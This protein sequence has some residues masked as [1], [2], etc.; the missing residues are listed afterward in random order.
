[1]LDLVL[2]NATI[3]TMDDNRRVLDNSSIGIENGR[4]LAIGPVKQLREIGAKNVLDCSGKIVIPGMVNTHTHLFQTLSKGLGSD[5]PLFDWFRKAVLPFAQILTE[6]DCRV[7]AL[8]GCVEAIKSG[9]TCLND[10]MYVHPKPKLS[11]AVIGAMRQV[12]VRGILSRGIVDSGRD[13]GMPDVLIQDASEYVEDCERLI[14]SYQGAYNGTIQ[15]W[16][17]PASLWMSSLD[18]FRKSK[19]VSK[20]HDIW[21]TW[22]C[23]ETRGVVD[24]S[25][26][27]FGKTDLRALHEIGFLGPNTLAA[28][29]IWLDEDEISI[30]K[31]QGVKVAHCP[32]ANMYLSDGVARIPYMLSKGITVGLGTDGAA[33]NDNQDM[34]F[35]LKTTPLL[36][37]VSSLDPLAMT[38]EKAFELATTGGANCLGLGRDIGSLEN[39][40]KADLVIINPNSANAVPSSRPIPSIVYTATQENVETVIVDGK[41]VMKDRKML[42]VREE[43]ILDKARKAVAALRSRAELEH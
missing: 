32:V 25:K 24:Y 35:L 36:H 26:Q 27:K 2:E 3:V 34:I 8:L 18:A 15:I 11:D 14:S 19:D 40:K 5:V 28:H 33:S 37:K 17:A 13:H 21:L 20:K 4:I 23:S 7:A 10:F 6:E 30:M 16:L 22:H 39:G 29:S 12:G 31:E 9:T 1:L 43:D 38:S 41:M 42:T